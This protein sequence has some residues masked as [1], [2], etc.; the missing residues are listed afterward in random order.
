MFGANNDTPVR[1]VIALGY[2]SLHALHVELGGVIDRYDGE[3]K[4]LAWAYDG[5]NPHVTYVDNKALGVCEYTTM[6]TVEL[7]ERIDNP[8]GKRIRKVWELGGV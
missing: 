1:R 4:N 2:H 5:F 6:D 8:K 7:V 3:V